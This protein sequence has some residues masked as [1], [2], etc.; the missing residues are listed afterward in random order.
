MHLVA[1]VRLDNR[2]ELI[3]KLAA[4]GMLDRQDA[5]NAGDA[6]LLLAAYRRWDEAC[7]EHL[8]GDFAF[9]VWD[10][11]R[12][13]IFAACDP[14]GTKPLYFALAGSVLCL[15]SEAQQVLRYPGIAWALDEIMVGDYLACRVPEPSRTFFRDVQ[16]LSPAHRL[17]A[18]AGDPRNVRIDRYWNLDASARI[19]YARDEDYA[20]HFLE[21]FRRAVGDRLRGSAGDVGILM[22]GGLDSSAVAAIASREDSRRLFAASFI[23][24]RLEEC[25][26]RRFIQATASRLGLDSELVAAERFP[27][28]DDPEA[29][30]PALEAPFAAWDACF[31]EVLRR[32]RA[33][34]AQVLLTG[35]GGDDLL[36]GSRLVYADRL[37]RGDLRAAWE[38]LRY[39][40][41]NRHAWSWIL[42]QHLVEPLLPPK[43]HRGLRRLT[44]KDSDA[45]VPDWIDSGF[46]RRTG[47]TE[48]LRQTPAR[49]FPGAARAAV[50]DYVRHTPWDRS[51]HWYGQHAAGFGIEVRHPFL[52]RRLIEYL[53]SIPQAQVFRVH[54]SKNLLR[55][56]MAGLLPEEVRMRRSKTHLGG[57]LAL[58]LGG[59][60]RERIERLLA[61]PL[62]SEMG[63]LDEKHLRA[64][65]QR[66]QDGKTEFDLRLWNP[67]ALELW[68]RE[69]HLNSGSASATFVPAA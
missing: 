30:R 64:A 25:D 20:S 16:R 21:L 65:Y 50:H 59:E 67:I 17:V 23:F 4:D 69:H 63:I 28:L 45:A 8:L 9:A 52:D 18:D 27:V 60:R 48:R 53:A 61:K 68:L 10:S 62:S 37:W 44:G 41:T 38:V 26:E 31:H 22:S 19:T 33:R 3:E 57:F 12:R 43:V 58:S 49:R 13:R 29:Q 6:E 55:Q 1:D 24:D 51:S 56:A 54:L 36:W 39:A 40:A 32:A 47:L 5:G 35:H 7:A 66:T 15:A 34:G 46:A 2:Q 11:R 42:Y 14:L